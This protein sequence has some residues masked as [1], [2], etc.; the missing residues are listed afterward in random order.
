[1]EAV[2]ASGDGSELVVEAFY[3]TVG[4]ACVDVRD[5]S[6]E[7]TSYRTSSSHERRKSGPGGPGEPVFECSA[8]SPGLE[9]VESASQGFLEQIRTV[10]RPLTMLKFAQFVS[11]FFGER[12]RILE[13]GPSSALDALGLL[14]VFPFPDQ[15]SPHFVQSVR[16]ETLDMETVED[17][18]GIRHVFVERLEIATGHVD[19]GHSKLRDSFGSELLEEVC[20]G[21]STS[22]LTGPH[23]SSPF[24]VDDQSEIAM[25]LTVAELIDADKTQPVELAGVAVAID[26]S[27]D[28]LTDGSPSDAGETGD[29]RL[30]GDLG[31]VG[32]VFFEGPGK[33][34][35]MR[36]PRDVLGS[37]ATPRTRD[38]SR[39]IGEPDGDL[40]EGE[41]SPSP[42]RPAIV[43]WSSS[44]T[45]STPGKD[46]ARPDGD[47]EVSIESERD[48]L[49]EQAGDIDESTQ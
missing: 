34:T 5:N 40:A 47:A 32:D 48:V 2:G 17:D 31:E 16:S 28:D 41:M 29:L 9:V 7:M 1:M 24:M 38:S 14:S 39:F 19:G 43:A 13:Q 4:E 42:H 10:E 44:A 46:L 25:P 35:G 36:C 12:P 20:K 27:L 6:F 21:L 8:S 26:D 49:N 3:E 37:Y 18:R 11:F 45:A 33:S 23:D 15:A 30:I 22:S